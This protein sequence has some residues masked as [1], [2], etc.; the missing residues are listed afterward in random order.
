MNIK[1]SDIKACPYCGGSANLRK[2]TIE[3]DGKHVPAYVVKCS[4]LDCIMST[5]GALSCTSDQAVDSWNTR[6]KARDSEK[7]PLLLISKRKLLMISIIPFGIFA[8]IVIFLMLL[9]L[10]R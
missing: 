10:L 8:M 7:D 1:D 2:Q 6:V 3:E 5:G 9:Y 4:N